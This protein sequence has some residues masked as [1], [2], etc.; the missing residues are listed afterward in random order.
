[1]RSDF[2]NRVKDSDG[3]HQNA[4]SNGEPRRRARP[5]LRLIVNAGTPRQEL[6][7]RDEDE[8]RCSERELRTAFRS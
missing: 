5:E 3:G 4:D 8:A 1:M 7:Q 6:A 2:R